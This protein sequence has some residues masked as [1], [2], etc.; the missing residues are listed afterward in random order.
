MRS[1]PLLNIPIGRRLALGFL[2]PAL[3]AALTLSNVG[4]Q[5]QQ[6]LL[7]ESTF[8]QH[9]FDAYTSLTSEGDMLQQMHTNLQETISYA[10]QQHAIPAILKDD[11][12]EEHTSE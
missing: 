8:Y 10:A 12:S 9:L 3:I 2:I 6:R 11:R 7:Q 1:N 4:V 5:S